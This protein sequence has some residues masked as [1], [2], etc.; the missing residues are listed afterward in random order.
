MEG[1]KPGDVFVVGFASWLGPE[2]REPDSPSRTSLNRMTVESNDG[3]IVVLTPSDGR[4]TPR[5]RI[6]L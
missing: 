1:S 2:R 5:L 3:Q 4:D 6:T